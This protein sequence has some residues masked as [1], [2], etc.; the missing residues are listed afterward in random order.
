MEVFVKTSKSKTD[1][2]ESS[3]A[4]GAPWDGFSKEGEELRVGL[5]ESFHCQ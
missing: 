5:L 2:L 1:K 4:L 3:L